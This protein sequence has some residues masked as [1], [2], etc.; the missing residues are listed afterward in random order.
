MLAAPA[1]LFATP[2]YWYAMSG[3]LKTLFDRFTDLLTDRDSGGRGRR[4]ADRQ[5]WMLAVGVDP[6]LPAG[7]EEPFRLTAAYL[8]MTWKG[9][10]YLST[11]VPK[12]RRADQIRA[13]A[14]RLA[15]ALAEAE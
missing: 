15:A 10:L 9:G 1:I 2:V 3:R 5:M 8:G 4:L 14:A 13:F 11:A 6:E 7:F 12:R